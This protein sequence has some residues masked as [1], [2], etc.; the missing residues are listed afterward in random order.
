MPK[1]KV[2]KI[3]RIAKIENCLVVKLPKLKIAKL[4]NCQFV[5]L[6]SWSEVPSFLFDILCHETL[7]KSP[8]F[9]LILLEVKVSSKKV[10]IFFKIL[11]PSHN[12]WTLRTSSNVT[13]SKG[14]DELFSLWT[15]SPW[16]GNDICVQGFNSSLKASKLHHSVWNL[17][18]PQ[19][20]QRFVETIQALCCVNFWGCFP[21]DR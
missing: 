7:N 5:S 14:N 19:R 4:L 15:F 10:R 17:T 8:I 2:A 3:A 21:K 9:Y 12:I 6:R 1:L 18:S 16:F 20:N 11:W 13:S